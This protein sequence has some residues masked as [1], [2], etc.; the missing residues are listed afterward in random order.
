MMLL[1]STTAAQVEGW[2]S[3]FDTA[4]GEPATG[5]NSFLFFG[6][7]QVTAIAPDGAHYSVFD[8]GDGSPHIAVTRHDAAAG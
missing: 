7:A 2:R 3:Q 5:F 8:A 6:D 4:M 1:A